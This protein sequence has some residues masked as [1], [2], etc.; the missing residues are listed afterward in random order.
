MYAVCASHV[1]LVSS[2]VRNML[3]GPLEL[4]W[5]IVVSHSMRAENQG[6][7]NCWPISL[8]STV[9]VLVRGGNLPLNIKTLLEDI[10]RN[11]FLVYS[12][13]YLEVKFCFPRTDYLW[14]HYKPVFVLCFSHHVW[15][16]HLSCAGALPQGKWHQPGTASS[17]PLFSFSWALS[18]TLSV[19]CSLPSASLLVLERELYGSAF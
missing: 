5:Q 12:P 18:S 6:D 2:R 13:R 9:W 10:V 16:T 4:E 19:S 14:H 17:F 1:C 7:L 3:S 11:Y 8:A 15:V